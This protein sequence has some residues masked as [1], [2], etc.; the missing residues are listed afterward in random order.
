MQEK[1]FYKVGGFVRDYL[2]GIKPKDVDWIAIGYNEQDLLDLGYIKIEGKNFPVFL[3]HDKEEVALARIEKST[4]DGYH[5]FE[6]ITE[7]VTLEEDLKRRDLTINA[8][9]M[10]DK[11][12]IYDPYGGRED[13]KN[14][15][16]RHTSD[17]FIEDPVRAL[18]VARLSA[19]FPDFKIHHKTLWKC[20]EMKDKL[21]YES[22]DRMWKEM[23][24]AFE[25]KKPSNFFHSLLEMDLLDVTFPLISDMNM[26]IQNPIHHAEGDVLTH[27]LMVLDELTNTDGV[28]AETMFAGL[29][30]DIGKP[31]VGNEP[32]KHAEHDSLELVSLLI[33]EMKEMY[34]IPNSFVNRAIQVASLHHRF[35]NIDNTSTRK[36]AKLFRVKHFPKRES[37]LI[38]VLIAI[39]AD[40][41]GRI[42][43]G[44]KKGISIKRATD[45]CSILREIK[46]FSPKS[47]IIDYMNAHGVHPSAEHIKQVI[48]RN[49]IQVV[50]KVLKR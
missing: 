28:E 24:K 27:T 23:L 13:L 2:L 15:I 11:G 8:M 39:N 25:S 32:T 40:A 35:H 37:D 26:C 9:A 43:D 3:N 16:L 17:A 50:R 38:Q 18:R 30:H 36:I 6:C 45:L 48:H 22:K 47:A 42:C 46:K 10:D 20:Y 4:G 41:H 33:N 44:D 12:I 49:A 7:N 5:D 29:V 1:K 21:Q 34:N 31:H 19:R 14:K